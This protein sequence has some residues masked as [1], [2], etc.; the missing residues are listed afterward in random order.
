MSD[1]K[2]TYDLIIFDCDGVLVDS[3]LIANRVL[4]EMLTKIGLPTSL[5]ESIAQYMGLSWAAGQALMEQNL[6]RSLPITFKD[7][8]HA[9]SVESFQTNLQPVPGIR[10]VLLTLDWVHIPYC[11]ASSGSHE[12]I[13]TTL[14]L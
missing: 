14:G 12:K 6:G 11:V 9:R 8:F 5:E 10:D 13:S 1:S 7:D 3:E 4:A 2:P